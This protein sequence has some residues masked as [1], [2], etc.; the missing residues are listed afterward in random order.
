MLAGYLIA[1]KGTLFFSMQEVQQLNFGEI[2]SL[3]VLFA[4]A[5]GATFLLNQLEDIETDKKNNKLFFLS[6]KHISPR[7]AKIEV[8]LLSLLSL[9]IAW[10]FSIT[11][12]VITLLFMFIT[13]YTYNYAPFF[14][15]NRPIGSVIANSLMGILAF[16]LGWFVT[17]T[18]FEQFI[19]E[20]LPYMFLNTALY[21]FT[22]LPDLE[23]DKASNK[24]TLA[25]T[26]GLNFVINLAL[27]NFVLGLATSVYSKDYYLLAINLAVLP[28]FIRLTTNKSVALTIKTTKYT[29]LFFGVAIC[30]KIPFYLVFLILLLLVTKWYYAK[31]FNYDY[32]NLKGK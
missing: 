14:L 29:I 10:S 2:F 28:F 23:G 17:Q 22:T 13:G 32:P 12:V 27:I 20:M 24:N 5:M 21:Y 31:R 16:A 4:S 7:A 1:S 30:F 18:G 26:H 15:K 6:E 8:V 25:V 19:I 9:I 11:I 3:I